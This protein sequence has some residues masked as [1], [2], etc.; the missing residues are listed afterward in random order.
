M[1]MGL[2]VQVPK[3]FFFFFPPS[4]GITDAEK[5]GTKGIAVTCTDLK[6]GI[7]KL[8]LNQCEMDVTYV[9]N[10]SKPISGFQF[11]AFNLLSFL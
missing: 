8:S 4:A 3:P 9:E 2:L 7:Y 11:K 10:C 6:K 1:K 5:S